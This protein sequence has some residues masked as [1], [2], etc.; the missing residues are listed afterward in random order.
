MFLTDV[1]T[2]KIIHAT[3]LSKNKNEQNFIRKTPDA[4]LPM[5]TVMEINLPIVYA[6]DLSTQE[7]SFHIFHFIRKSSW[8]SDLQCDFSTAYFW[9]WSGNEVSWFFVTFKATDAQLPSI[10][11]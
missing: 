11:L 3:A 10:D 6:F 2:L 5:I 1:L 9:S 8:Y 7:L 4:K